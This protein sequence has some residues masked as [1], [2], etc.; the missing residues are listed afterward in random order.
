[1]ILVGLTGGIGAGKSTVSA[2]LAERGE[3]WCECGEGEGRGVLGRKGSQDSEAPLL[4][5]TG[6]VPRQVCLSDAG[7]SR[8]CR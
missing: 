7:R 6:Q 4:G 8:D 2:L 3:Q 1:M 5:F